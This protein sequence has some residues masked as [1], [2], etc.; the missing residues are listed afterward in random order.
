MLRWTDPYTTMDDKWRSQFVCLDDFETRSSEL[1]PQRTWVYYSSGAG[2]EDT[3]RENRDAFRRYWL[4]PRVLRDVSVRD[5]STTV[6]GEKIDMPICI[7]PTAFHG[8]AHPEGEIATCKA[9]AD[10]KTLM[11]LSAGSTTSLEDITAARPTSAKWQDIYFWPDRTAT[12]DMVK[13]AEIAGFK[14]IV[15]TVDIP[16]I[17]SRRKHIQVFGKSLQPLQP[18]MQ[19]KNLKKYMNQSSDSIDDGKQFAKSDNRSTW[20]DIAWLKT[21][22]TLPIVLKG[23]LTVEDAILAAEHHVQAIMVSNH[24]ARQLDSV[25]ATIDVLSEIVAAVGDKLEVYV[26]GG[27]RTGTDVLKALALGA[28]AVFIGRPV[29]FGLACNGEEGV[30][31]VLHILREELSTAMALTGCS[32]LRDISRDLVTTKSC[33]SKL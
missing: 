14:A 33:W 27:V 30:K 8:L 21:M 7:S 20:R 10:M 6:L 5:M 9:A 28:R 15:V 12:R 16:E 4:K 23:I 1:L 18:G 2:D 26:D 13:R 31:A 17:G 19:L 22:T 32:R 29:L 24:G 25:P 3:L 11:I